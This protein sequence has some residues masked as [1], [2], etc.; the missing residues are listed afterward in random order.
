MNTFRFLTVLALLFPQAAS[1]SLLGKWYVVYPDE[2]GWVLHE[3][4]DALPEHCILEKKADGSVTLTRVFGHDAIILEVTDLP[5]CSDQDTC[6]LQLQNAGKTFPLVMVP[7]KAG[8]REFHFGGLTEVG[9]YYVHETYRDSV[10]YIKE[11]RE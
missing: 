1:F 2:Q 7:E 4:W 10:R 5:S 9:T 3:P 11:E 8:I 6:T